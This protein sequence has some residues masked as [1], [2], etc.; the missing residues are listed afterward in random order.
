MGPVLA[1]LEQLARHAGEILRAGYHQS[2]AVDRKGEINLVTEMDRRSEAYLLEA[3]G[4]RFP[5]HRVIAEET[6]GLEGADACVWYIDPLD[7]T[8]NYAH[9]LPIFSV[10]IAYEEAGELTFG[11]VYDPMSDEMFSAERGKG[12]CVNGEPIRVGS[13]VELSSSL[14]VTGFPYDRFINP[15]NN[16]EY[17]NRFTLRV[18]GIRRLGSAALD[19]CFV[20]CG[21]VD[22]FWEI[23]LEPWDLAAGTLIAREA[24]ALVTKLDGTLDILSAPYNVVAANPD[25]HGEMLG[26]LH[27]ANS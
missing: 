23:R 11:V 26:V 27:Q 5:E 1:D 20:A 8:T 2:N 6:G 18:Q 14:L 19:L 22:G 21:R 15:D 10:S 17:F 7:G 4:K 12:A 9:K 16:L 3:I 24:G 25:L 13:A